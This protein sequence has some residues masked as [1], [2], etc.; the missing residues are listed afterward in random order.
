[1]ATSLPLAVSKTTALRGLF[2]LD[3]LDNRYPSLHGMRVLAIVSVVQWHTTQF[4][5]VDHGLPLNPSWA[6]ASLSVF[7]GMDLFFVLSGFLIGS[8]LMRSLDRSGLEHVRRFYL[9][10]AFRTF[11]SYYVVLTFLALAYSLSPAQLY[12]LPFEYVYLTNY[13]TTHREDLLMAWGWSLAVEEQFYLVVPF[14][15]LLLRKIGSDRARLTL[16]ATMWISALVI[17]LLESMPPRGWWSALPSAALYTRTHTRFDTLV[18]GIILAFVHAR[19]HESIARWL[20]RPLARAMLALPSLACLWVLMNPRIFGDRDLPGVQCVYW[21]TLTSLM[22]MGWVLL[23]LDGGNGWIQRALS[24][25]P[26]R[27]IATLGYGVYL[28]HV[29]LFD[30]IARLVGMLLQ[31]HWSMQVIWPISVA[32]LMVTSLGVSYLLHLIVDKPSLRL[33]DRLAG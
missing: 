26:F 13:R 22:Y 7:F 15:F 14:L 27:R 23:L 18:A 4:L 8:I 24:I 30:V 32:L 29:P 11:P 25:R 28:V 17:R 9:R 1:M 2:D 10:R 21:G 31:K 3:L 20:E 12:N 16:L 6:S 19:W 33:R 5:V